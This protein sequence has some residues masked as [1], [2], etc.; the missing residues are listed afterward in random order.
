MPSLHEPTHQPPTDA[1]REWTVLGLGLVA[2]VAILGLTVAIVAFASSQSD[3]GTATAA[4]AR[5]AAKATAPHDHS[6][7]TTKAATTAAAET[8]Q[9]VAFE[10]FEWVDPTLPAVPAGDVKK[11]TVGVDEHVVKVDPG[12]PP[13]DAWTYTVNGTVYRGTAA[14]PPIVVNQGDKVQL[15]FVNGASEDMHVTMGHSIDFHSAEVA[16]NKYYVDIAP[17][18]KETIRFTAEHAGVFMYHCATQPVLMHVGNG[19]AGMMVVKPRDLPPVDRE[20]WIDQ[21][22]Y[23]LGAAG[24]PADMTKLTE[25]KP[26]VIAFNGFA[27][28]YKTK[29]IDV[30]QGE[31]IRMY[32]LNTGPSKWSAFH[33]IGTVFDRVH[34]DNGEATDVQTISLA[35]SQGAWA[36]FTL[37]QEGNYPFLTHN[38]GDMMKGAVGMLHTAGAPD[39]T[40]PEGAPQAARTQPVAQTTADA[41]PV[42]LGEMWIKTPDATVDAGKVTFAIKNAGAAMHQFA[43]YRTPVVAVKGSPDPAAAVAAGKMLGAG[44]DETVTADLKPGRYELVCLMAGHYAAGQK[45]A[46]TVR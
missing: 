41:V 38:F 34:S 28:Q 26:D 2:L 6:A 4:V 18:E 46:F 32:V 36:E 24:E 12:Q 45:L 14:S 17:G 10:P 16:P 29:P 40:A 20:L 9:D 23:Y 1:R 43:I 30:R 42:E 15:T 21:S 11:F 22:E 5:P 27:N 37:D 25:E 8:G 44:E 7:M 13:T 35:P 19:M 39:A 31:R 3:A 33:V